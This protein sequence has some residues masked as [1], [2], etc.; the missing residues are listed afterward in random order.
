M[1]LIMVLL[2]T[3]MIH[4]VPGQTADQ[5]RMRLYLHSRTDTLDTIPPSTTE[6]DI[7]NDVMSP[8][9]NWSFTLSYPLTRDLLL[10][11]IR[12]GSS[13]HVLLHLQGSIGTFIDDSYSLDVRLNYV[14][15][16]GPL[17]QIAGG[18]FRGQEMLEDDLALELT[19]QGG[20]TVPSGS[21]IELSMTLEGTPQIAVAFTF[22]I[23]S[24]GGFSYLEF[25]ASPVRVE[26]ISVS[27]TDV[28]GR[29]LDELL[30]NGPDEARTFNVSVAVSD[31]FGA[32][33]IS[34]VNILV[35]S[36]NE[37]VI[38][39]QT[40]QPRENGG[41]KIAYTNFT[42]TLPE[43]T[44]EDVYNIIASVTSRTGQTSEATGELTV[45]SGLLVT[46][47][48][49]DREADAGET[50]DIS[51]DILNGGEGTDRVD[52]SYTS[53]LGWAVEAPDPVE[54][55]G[56][57][58]VT[59]EFTV[60]VPIRASKGD[61]DALTLTADSRN[62]G[63]SYSRDATVLVV[64]EASFGLEAVSDTTK[65]VVSGGGVQ[66]AA[67]IVNLRNVSGTFEMGMDE[68]P[69]DWSVSY[70]GGNGTM[71]GSI[72][73]IT[74][75][76]GSEEVMDIN[77]LTGP[78]SMGT[79]DMEL[80]VRERGKTDKKYIYLHVRVVD[81]ER[82]L[83][84]LLDTTDTKLS[85]RVGS[86]HPIRYSEVFFTLELYN[87]T[88]EEN[89]V[90]IRVDRPTGWEVIYDYNE[91]DL[92][93]GESSLWNIS[94]IPREGERYE[95]EPYEVRVDVNG[96]DMGSFEQKLKVQLKKIISLEMVPDRDRFDLKEGKEGKVNLTVRNRGNID[97]DVDISVEVPANMVVTF[98]PA[99]L[100]V[101][102]GEDG[103]VR[104]TVKLL[105]VESEGE[106]TFTVSYDTGDVT[107]S[108]EITVIASRSTEKESVFNI[109]W[110][111]IGIIA[112]VVIIAFIVWFLVLRKGKGRNAGGGPTKERPAGSS[113]DTGKRQGPSPST[114]A[115]P[116]VKD[117][118]LS[119]ADDIAASILAEEK[120]KREVAGG[121]IVE[122]EAPRTEV[123]EAEILE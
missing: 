8:G 58:T 119:R 35:M 39:N 90:S 27:V 18:I 43:G 97:V 88:L 38:L 71:Q 80:F 111:I 61:R 4:P 34:E 69:A 72:F 14:T 59:V 51:M 103:T 53:E 12:D 110:L 75:A 66:F 17:V 82:S 93:P 104:M 7:Q 15:E 85:S 42:Y 116:I 76:G 115:R 24:T 40:G 81:P 118:L 16:T 108:R 22:R 79:Y 60:L 46:V 73:V 25:A 121:V 86:N 48:D 109:L 6:I 32:Y 98:E 63:R 33:D 10:E 105:K 92:L 62:S 5:D 44:P 55:E 123:V 9:E 120:G 101:G 37:L 96:G 67:R 56:G 64:K 99:S 113:G 65:A 13:V 74:I 106:T 50:V 28:H 107:G 49:P 100:S 83:A 78:S 87:P 122:A 114:S 21:W 89:R 29:E 30:P 91:L 117:P 52:F 95:S 94:I 19:S 23:D 11:G 84:T 77:I 26:D 1:L 2:S 54:V 36:D 20:E 45:S 112:A 41:E 31:A 70:S 102:M 47:D 3:L 57:A 68:R